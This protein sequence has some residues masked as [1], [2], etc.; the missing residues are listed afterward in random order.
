MCFFPLLS[1][2]TN[3]KKV[4][5]LLFY[6]TLTKYEH[7][8][9]HES[10]DSQSVVPSA[11]VGTELCANRDVRRQALRAACGVGDHGQA[12]SGQEHEQAGRVQ[13]GLASRLVHQTGCHGH[14]QETDD[15]H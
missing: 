15:A 1:K 10:Q 3:R 6:N 11:R 8:G 7:H 9:A 4:A 5:D 2:Q 14:R 13:Q 12:Q